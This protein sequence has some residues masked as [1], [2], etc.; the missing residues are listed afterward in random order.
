MASPVW[1]SYTRGRENQQGDLHRDQATLEQ[2]LKPWAEDTHGESPDIPA[3]RGELE[4]EGGAK[5]NMPFLHHQGPVTPIIDRYEAYGLHHV[6]CAWERSLLQA[7]QENLISEWQK[8][9]ET[10]VRAAI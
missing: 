5:K 10:V 8:I 1:F 2:T 7:A 6:V 9:P 4:K 3:R